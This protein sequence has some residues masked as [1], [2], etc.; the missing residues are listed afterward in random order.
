MTCPRALA[1]NVP[2]RLGHSGPSTDHPCLPRRAPTVAAAA[3]AMV[4]QADF[5]Q[6]LST[7]LAVC[8]SKGLQS[9]W[10]EDHELRILIAHKGTG[11]NLWDGV[12]PQK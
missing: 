11:W 12:E 7:Q 5:V 6:E 9:G 1:Q 3:A 10:A 2:N 8:L 4:Q